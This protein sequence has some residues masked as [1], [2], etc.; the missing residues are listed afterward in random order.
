MVTDAYD[1]LIY[2]GQTT[3]DAERAFGFTADAKGVNELYIKVNYGDIYDTE[4]ET[5]FVLKLMC[6]GKRI[7]SIDDI[8]AN[9]D[10]KLVVSVNEEIT[11][12]TDVYGA[13]YSGNTMKFANKITLNPGD[14]G[15][16]DIAINLEGI[17]EFDKISGYVWKDMD[18]VLN[19]VYFK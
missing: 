5:G 14:T 6:D 16:Y 8:T 1:E 17:S 7:L 2:A 4:I 3:C 19:G 11:A 15:E 10:V 12:K 13:V 18:P 9:G